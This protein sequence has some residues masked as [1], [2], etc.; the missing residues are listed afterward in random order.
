MAGAAGYVQLVQP[1]DTA[2]I[3]HHGDLLANLQRPDFLLAD[4]KLYGVPVNYGPLGLAYNVNAVKS[5]P[6]SWKA[7]VESGQPFAVSTDWPE[8]NVAVAGLIAGVSKSKA[9]DFDSLNTPGVKSVLTTM[10][11]KS[12]KKWKGI[13]DAATLKLTFSE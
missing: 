2:T 6:V 3:S 7:L 8:A 9:F 4:G 13:D 1:V 10:A 11:K 5:V 12:A